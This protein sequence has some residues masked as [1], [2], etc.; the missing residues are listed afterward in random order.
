[1]G[2]DRYIELDRVFDW[3]GYSLQIPIATSRLHYI[4]GTR[5]FFTSIQPNSV[6]LYAHVAPCIYCFVHVIFMPI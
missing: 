3:I 4:C 6:M 1:M 5:E 2:I